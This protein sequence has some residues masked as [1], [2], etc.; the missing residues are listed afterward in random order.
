M[1]RPE[2]FETISHMIWN[3]LI[4]RQIKW[5]IVSKFVVFSENLNFNFKMYNVHTILEV[6]DKAEEVCN[7]RRVYRVVF[8]GGVISKSILNLVS[9][10]QKMKQIT[11]S[12]PFNLK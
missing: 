11:V 12:Q 1:K 2:K 3:L 9:S 4:K 10:P 5:K 6:V 7:S 8:K